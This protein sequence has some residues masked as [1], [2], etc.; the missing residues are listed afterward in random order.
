[1]AKKYTTSLLKGLEKKYKVISFNTLSTAN[2]RKG[3]RAVDLLI[4]QKMLE[5]SSIEIDQL[6]QLIDS[7][8]KRVQPRGVHIETIEN[9]HYAKV[10]MENIGGEE[11][12]EDFERIVPLSENEV[13]K[14]LDGLTINIEVSKD[15]ALGLF[16][17]FVFKIQ[18]NK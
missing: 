6:V 9:R 10:N 16:D 15:E 14:I 8:Q 1:M 17:G 3:K 13:S 12:L 2:Q 11:G 18:N 7:M 5:K 4:M